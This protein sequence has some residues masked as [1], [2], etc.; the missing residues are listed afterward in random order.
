MFF[1]LFKKKERLFTERE[2]IAAYNKGRQDSIL[3]RDRTGYE[4]LKSYIK[5]TSKNY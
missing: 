4:W 2:M 3:L 5:A 1:G